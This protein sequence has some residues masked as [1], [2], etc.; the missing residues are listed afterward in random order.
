MAERRISDRAVLLAALVL[1]GFKPGPLFIPENPALFW[2]LVASM[3]LGN[4]ML[5]LVNIFMI[6][7][8]ASVA[9]VPF[10]L[11]GPNRRHWVSYVVADD[12]TI[13]LSFTYSPIGSA[14]ATSRL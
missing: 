12:V 14:W 4:I 13:T 7:A 8:F 9:R 3:Y 10:R 11:L 5:L 6:P 1:W 2:G